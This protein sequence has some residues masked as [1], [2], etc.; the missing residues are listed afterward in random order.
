M[1]D[2]L[3]Q[4]ERIVAGGRYL[5]FDVDDIWLVLGTVLVVD[6]MVIQRT[7]E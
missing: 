1:F 6:H 4:E 7:S 3:F 2:C 5:I